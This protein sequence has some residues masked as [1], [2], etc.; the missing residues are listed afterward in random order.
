MMKN[1]RG[2]MGSQGT[3]GGRRGWSGDERTAFTAPYV[4]ATSAMSF[5][6]PEQAASAARTVPAPALKHLVFL[7]RLCPHSTHKT[8][9]CKSHSSKSCLRHCVGSQYVCVCVLPP[10][11][12]ME[13]LE[14]RVKSRF[15]HRKMVLV[16]SPAFEVG[17]GCFCVTTLP[18]SI[19]AIA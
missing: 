4:A 11:D 3:E 6:A 1:Y 10:Q 19:L 9:D 15:S 16:P 7:K 13:S 8:S 14:K 18:W 5:I 17:G 2:G 12:V